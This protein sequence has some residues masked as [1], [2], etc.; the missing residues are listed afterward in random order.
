MHKHKQSQCKR[1]VKHRKNLMGL[2]IFC[3]TVCIVFMFAYYQNLRK[4]ISVRQEWL[5]TVLTREK[6]WILENQGPEGEFYMNGSKA[7]DVNPYFACMAALGLLA[8]TKNCPMTE[9]EQKAVG[10][11][12]DWHTGVLLETDG[13]MGIYRKEGG[14]LIYKEKADSEDGYLGMYL[15][16]M[17]KYLEKTESTDLPESWKNG[18]S[19]ALK[20]IQSL[21]QDGITQVSEENTTV[22]L[23]DNLEVWKGLYELELAGLEDTQAISEIR[24]KIQKQIEKIFWDDANQ[25]WRIIGNSDRYHQTEFYPDG[26]AQIYPLIYE[27]PVK[28]KKKQKVLYDQFTERFQ[29][30][31]L[32][33]K[34]TG[35]LWAMTGM[36]A[37]QM[38]D[39]NNLVE[40]V[41]NYETEYCKKRKYPL[42]T[43][44]AGWICM[45]CEKLYSLYEKNKNRI[46]TMYMILCRVNKRIL[47]QFSKIVPVKTA[48]LQYA[49]CGC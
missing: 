28:E 43:G 23:M 6:K 11:Y 14:E 41:G 33:K 20:K 27:F 42:Y 5:E 7:G 17:G 24:K 9:T 36:A 25:R 19:L 47:S 48:Y 22:Y 32:N 30:Q 31:K 35:F 37:A 4:E 39:I 46:Y 2:I 3:I 38:R 26:V 18:I 45:E 34:R 16:L 10:R 21:M 49:V 8:E 44:E 40:L 15:F 1:K 29:W 13:K 12:L